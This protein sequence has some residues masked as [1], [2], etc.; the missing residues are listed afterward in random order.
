MYVGVL[1]TPSNRLIHCFPFACMEEIDEEGIKGKAKH[2]PSEDARSH[3][4]VVDVKVDI[5]EK[6][7]ANE[8]IRQENL[9]NP[10]VVEV[11]GESTVA[12]R[13]PKQILG[14]DMSQDQI[15]K[16]KAAEEEEYKAAR[17]K[18]ISE[19]KKVLEVK[20]PTE[21]QQKLE[22][23]K[24]LSQKAIN[25]LGDESVRRASQIVVEQPTNSAKV[26]KVLG[27]SKVRGRKA[28]A[29]L[30]SPMTE[31]Q[32]K[33]QKHRTLSIAQPYVGG[34]LPTKPNGGEK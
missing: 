24:H 18:S 10:K 21:E 34:S 8:T 30:G 12:G 20:A 31:D 32:L 23:S 1:A 26:V 17:R 22:L 25:K 15:A 3:S 29:L 4:K 27:H 2:A 9:N 13:K 5:P 33:K 19:M 14:D 6:N 16:M 7:I 11:F 28:Y